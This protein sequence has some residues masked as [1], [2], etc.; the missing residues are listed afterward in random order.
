[1]TAWGV[2]C[3]DGIIKPS[4][5][6][7]LDMKAI[8]NRVVRVKALLIIDGDNIA[9]LPQQMVAQHGGCASAW[10]AA[11]AAL[12]LKQPLAAGVAFGTNSLLCFIEG[13]KCGGQI[14]Q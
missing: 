4:V 3:S 9:L 1:M 2:L 8:G 14:Q 10:L 13:M 12:T 6:I 7:S 11:A 5:V